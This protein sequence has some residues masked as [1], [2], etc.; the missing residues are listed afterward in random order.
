MNFTGRALDDLLRHVIWLVN[1]LMARPTNNEARREQISDAL[2]R[3]MAKRGY[4]GA[5]VADIAKAARL[6]PGLVHYHFDTKQEILLLALGRLVARHVSGL[7]ARLAQAEGD[8]A[9]ELDAFID[10][11]LG[12]GADAD[13]EAL[14][15]WILLSGEALR[16]PKVREDLERGLR[17]LTDRLSRLI[18]AGVNRGVFTCARVDAAASALLATIQGYFMLAGTARHLIPKGSAAVCTKQMAAGL[19]GMRDTST[20]RGRP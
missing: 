8:P 20:S 14:A 18:G 10:F 9:A 15:C 13:P 2:I 19:L 17:L 5:S 6:T 7:E 3:V 4:D 1:Q 12:L 11:H 16:E